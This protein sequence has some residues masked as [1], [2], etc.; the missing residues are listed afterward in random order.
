MRVSVGLLLFGA[1]ASP[2]MAQQDVQIQTVAAAPG[3]HMLVGSGG[4]IGVSSG[5]DG[6]FVIDDQYAPLTYKIVVA[7]RRFSTEPIRFVV[8]THWHGDH[9]GG[10]ENMGELGALIVAHDNVRGRMSV[11]QVME[12][13]GR[14]VP[15]SPKGALPVVTFSETTTFHLNGD[16]LYVFHVP[17]AHTDGDAI[18]HFRRGNVVHMGDTFFNGA[19]PFI[20]L[21][22]G[23]SIDGMI[24]AADAVLARIDGET[25]IIPGHGA[26][27]TRADLKAYRD[28]LA[29]ARDRVT[30]AIAKGMTLEQAKAAKLMAEYDEAW[31]QA[32]I[33]PNQFVEF[34]YRSLRAQ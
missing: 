22:S 13:L 1:V 27:G 24:H 32:F 9:V 33:N 4:N 14:T 3:I 25:K 23:G 17:H 15:A 28:V 8:N 10:N 5:P 20:D 21:G 2:L 31:G 19:Y 18:I 11:K 26:L 7:I 12:A 30:D 34:V 16:E 6:V 29:I